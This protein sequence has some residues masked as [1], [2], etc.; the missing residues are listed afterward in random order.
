[1]RLYSDLAP[2]WPLLS[3]PSDYA[4]EA[5][6]FLPMLRGHPPEPARAATQ[7][8][9]LLE[10]GSGGGNLASHLA[11][12]FTLTLCD[13]APDM[14]AVSRQLNPG[15]EH[16]EG[17]MRTV[18]LGRTFDAVLIHDAIVYMTT[19]DDLRA[20]LQTA[21]L[22]CRPGGTVVV[23]P[24][25]VRETFRPGTS[26]GG[27]DGDD[28][29]ALRYLEWSTDPDPSDDTIEV[30]YSVILREADGAARVELDRHLEGCFSRDAWLRAFANAGLDARSAVD[31]WEREV[32]VARHRH[33]P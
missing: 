32:F 8:P 25:F 5:D 26:H 17:D 12:Y 2:W 22:H 14:L 21:A 28:G 19:W 30:L 6:A 16:V 11:P 1:M 9:T 29:R 31:P 15:V 18:R 23:A 27:E 3:A 33:A 4:E 24:D 13:V 10:L 7:R 20:A